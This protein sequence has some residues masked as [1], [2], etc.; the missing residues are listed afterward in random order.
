MTCPCAAPRIHRR[1]V[2]LLLQ[3]GL[4]AVS[5]THLELRQTLNRDDRKRLLRL[6]DGKNLLVESAAL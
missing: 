5:Y 3:P 2:F 1:A 4:G 6:V